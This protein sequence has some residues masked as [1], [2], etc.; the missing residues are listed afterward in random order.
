M[1]T[2]L[3][4][5]NLDLKALELA[6][7]MEAA[8]RLQRNPSKSQC[9]LTGPHGISTTKVQQQGSFNFSVVLLSTSKGD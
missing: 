3:A 8:E 9:R 2:F 7:C 5:A 1:Y 4:E 6:K